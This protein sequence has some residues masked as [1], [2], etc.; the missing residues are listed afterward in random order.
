MKK[1]TVVGSGPTGALAALRLLRANWDV[2]ML[3]IGSATE[4]LKSSQYLQGN[5]IKEVNGLNFPYDINQYLK[6]SGPKRNWYSSKAK[7]GFSIVWGATWKEPEKSTE[8]DSSQIYS[9][10]VKEMDGFVTSFSFLEPNSYQSFA[11]TCF[12]NMERDYLRQG[13]EFKKDVKFEKS[14]MAVKLSKCDFSGRCHV[15]CSSNAIW[16]SLNILQKC[17]AFSN[18]SYIDNVFVDRFEIIDDLIQVTTSQRVFKTNYLLLGAGPIGNSAIL[19]NSNEANKIDILDTQMITIPLFSM[20]KKNPHV[21]SFGLSGGFIDGVDNG[22]RFSIQLYSHPETFLN[23]I[24]D[25]IPSI[26]RSVI[27]PL[28]KL[29]LPHLY[30]AII[31][32]DSSVSGKIILEKGS[33][34]SYRYMNFDSK[35]KEFTGIRKAINKIFFGLRI[36]PAWTFAKFANVGDSYHIG[37]GSGFE[38]NNYGQ[39]KSNPKVGILGSLALESIEPGPITS[40][41]MMQAIKLVNRFESDYSQNSERI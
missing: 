18:F 25:A 20:R 8:N 4:T 37:A 35:S 34:L 6:M 9:E 21:G 41:S 29:M 27:L 3:D 11:C 14:K 30:I 7:G 15:K 39:L 5:S 40:L 23:R 16:S 1:I 10:L 24:S 13:P 36:F 19:L 22:K 2:T 26:F 33:A 38:A 12:D 17:E 28:M 32:L 31:Y